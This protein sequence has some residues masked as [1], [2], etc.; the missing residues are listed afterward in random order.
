MD[1]F[2]TWLM[3]GGL[4]TID[5]PSDRDL[6]HRRALRESQAAARVGRTSRL[7]RLAASV[8]STFR[9]TTTTQPDAACCAA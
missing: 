2:A 3:N 1:N 4:D 5:V 9:A 7:G 8:R 6:L